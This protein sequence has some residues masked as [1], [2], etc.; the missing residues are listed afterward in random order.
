M[1]PASRGFFMGWHLNRDMKKRTF[2]WGV[3]AVVATR[4]QMPLDLSPLTVMQGT[5]ERATTRSAGS[6]M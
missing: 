5:L 1:R 6:S 4:E 3:V 2:F